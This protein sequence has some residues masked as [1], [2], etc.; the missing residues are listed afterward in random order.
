AS[1]ERRGA[2]VGLVDEAV[3]ADAARRSAIA[4]FESLRA[5]QNA[6]GKT[7]AK[8]PQD[9]K[10]GPVAQAQRPA[11]PVNEPHRS[12]PGAGTRFAAAAD[13]TP[14]IGRDGVPAGGH[15]DVATLGAVGRKPG[16][17]FARGD[18]TALVE[19][20]DDI[21]MERGAKVSGAVFY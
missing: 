3:E 12:A 14:A 2:S 20:L 13:G 4:A 15:I 16:S 6:F 11:A 5:E 9:E 21:S 17:E 7:V 8:A 18:R 19:F 1:Q 10:G